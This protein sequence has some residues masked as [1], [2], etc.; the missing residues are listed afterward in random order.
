MIGLDT[1]VVVRSLTQDDPAQCRA[2]NELFAAASGADE[3]RFRISHV[4]LAEVVLVLESIYGYARTDIARALGM[5]LTTRP[6]EVE[7]RQSVKLALDL[8]ASG[9]ADLADGLISLTY[10]DL[11]C[12]VTVTFDRKASAL[13]GMT[14]L[15]SR[16]Q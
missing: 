11:D 16:R 5:L 7:G 8:F 12:E 15:G 14:L 1:N 6:I 4:A 10:L 2:V 3:P 13:P 9:S